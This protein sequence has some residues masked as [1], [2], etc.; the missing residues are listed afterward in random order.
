MGAYYFELLSLP[1]LTFID[2]PGAALP[3]GRL[4]RACAAAVA[5]RRAGYL[6]SVAD[7]QAR[8]GTGHGHARLCV[9]RC[10]AFFFEEF[11]VTLRESSGGLLSKL[12]MS[13]H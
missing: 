12:P 6:C 13:S 10:G 9:R 5:S 8:A 7:T 2:T 3:A 1:I 4:P 11:A